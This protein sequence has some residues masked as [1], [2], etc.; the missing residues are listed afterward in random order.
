MLFSLP[1][2]WALHA[3]CPLIY[4]Y[5]LRK[6]LK[7]NNIKK[8]NMLFSLPIVWALHASCKNLVKRP[9]KSIYIYINLFITIK[10]FNNFFCRLFSKVIW[11]ACISYILYFKLFQ[12][13]LRLDQSSVLRTGS[14]GLT[15]SSDRQQNPETSD[16]HKLL[17]D[18]NPRGLTVRKYPTAEH[19]KLAPST[20]NE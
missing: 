8:L 15:E 1:I 5:C 6:C 19:Q 17:Y 16:R 4:R 13:G 10:L 14:A 20:L 11:L 3:S 18:R 9:D 2:V 12:T 7:L